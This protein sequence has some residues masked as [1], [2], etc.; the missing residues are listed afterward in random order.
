MTNQTL[1]ALLASL[2]SAC[3]LI[4]VNGKPLGGGSIPSSGSAS[5]ASSD[6]PATVP[7][8]SSSSSKPAPRH[9]DNETREEWEARQ[10]RTYEEQEKKAAAEKAAQLPFCSDYAIPP[11]RNIKLDWLGESL[12]DHGNWT[13]HVQGL[14][15]AMCA[16][17]DVPD[18]A[19]AMA[20]RDKWMK[21][22]GLDET[23]FIVVYALSKGRGW[24]NQN[25]DDVPGPVSQMRATDD[26]G[27]D[28]L[29]ARASMIGRFSHVDSCLGGKGTGL[30]QKILCA[31]E[32]LDASKAYAEV[33]ATD[34][35][36]PDNRYHIRQM[37]FTAAAA[38]AKAKTEIAALA[39]EEPGVAQ[40]VAIADAQRK[41]WA[42]PSPARAKLIRLVESMQAAA[43]TDKRSSFKGC[44]ATT[45][46]AWAEVVKGA[47][48]P[49]VVQSQ[50]LSTLLDA[51]FKTPE[52]YL[53]FRAFELCA[54]GVEA[55]FTPE[56]GIFGARHLRRGPRTSI[57]AA[58]MAVSGDI[59]FD[60]KSLSMDAL[61]GG[62]SLDLGGRDSD[63]FSVGTIDKVTPQGDK[64]VI[65]FKRDVVEIEDCVAWRKT[66]RVAGIESNGDFRYEQV[67]TRNGMVK[68]DRTPHD[69]TLS[70]LV[71]Q[72]LKPGM[73]FVAD[74]EEHFP[75][76]ATA[77]AKST[78][79]IWALGVAK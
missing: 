17:A 68:F 14:A 74:S 47:E 75:I 34:E 76:V 55:S 50:A 10:Q 24:K 15:E 54:D 31:T 67:C 19:K 46:A 49:T 5:S 69:V 40:L 8:G 35:L 7:Y 78:K 29:G 22:H 6:E 39:K 9:K 71:A 70:G 20:I 26:Y 3:G 41:E 58:W 65:S 13:R 33:E 64:V 61:F 42:S 43:N 44:E 66:N 27:L 51:V 32:P 62:I 52:A 12:T 38:Q 21:M 11:A 37:V 25:Y 59:K 57:I 1:L 18:R 48:L 77:S 53:A 23:D 30:L 56:T 60:S 4:N 28:V 73:F 45:G 79:A 36:T 72:G 16:K 2:S 63:R